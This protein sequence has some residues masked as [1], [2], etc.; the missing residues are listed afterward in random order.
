MVKPPD[1]P[2]PPEIRKGFLTLTKANAVLA[3]NPSWLRE[4]KADLQMHS[5][6]SDGS[7]SIQEMTEAGAERGYE[8]IAITDHAKGLKIAG[9]ID[10]KQLR[11]Q[12]TEI[13]SVNEAMEKAKYPTK[14]LRS[15]ELNLN[16]QGEG[17]IDQQG[18]NRLDIV[19]GCF[20]STLRKKE[21]KPHV[22]WRPRQ[23]FRPYSWAPSGAHL[24]FPSGPYRGPV[25]LILPQ[26]WTRPSRLTPTQIARIST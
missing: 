6:W 25:C 9:G 2:A 4:L 1:V 16:P 10:E 5:E 8:Y 17:D 26:N 13:I 11:A 7:A 22:I 15:V 23:S 3:E 24:Q 18:L 14:T 19:L 12:E 20:H 21:I